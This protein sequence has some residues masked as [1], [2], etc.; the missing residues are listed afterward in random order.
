MKPRT[1]NTAPNSGQEFLFI[2]LCTLA[3]LA[4]AVMKASCQYPH[5]I[6]LS[7]IQNWPNAQDQFQSPI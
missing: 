1:T 2:P 3:K 7:T 4:I 6:A 5:G